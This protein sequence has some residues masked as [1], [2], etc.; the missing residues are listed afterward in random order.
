MLNVLLWLPLAAGLNA[1]RIAAQA[2]AAGLPAVASSAFEAGPEGGI[3][4]LR[5]SLGGSAPRWRVRREVARLEALI[6]EASRSP[7]V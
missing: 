1:D 7:I 6:R 4:A 3:Q 2:V 5:I